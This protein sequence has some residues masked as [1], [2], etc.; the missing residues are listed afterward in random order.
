M[1]TN[2]LVRVVTFLL[3]S[4]AGCVCMATDKQ[5]KNLEA[6]LQKSFNQL[7]MAVSGLDYP[8]TV[9]MLND[10]VK[11][12]D[13]DCL[14]VYNH[15]LA[16]KK[17]IQSVSSIKSL[18]ITLDGIEKYCRSQDENLAN[19]TCNGAVLSLYFYTTVAQD[20]KILNRIKIYPKQ[21]KNIIF[22]NS[23]YWFYNRPN[24]DAWVSAISVMDIDWRNDIHK[25]RTLSLFRKD[26]EELKNETFVAK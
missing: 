26:I 19:F 9:D 12:N 23:F 13:K 14:R 18:D 20:T 21:I 4:L 3:F 10:C 16:G 1:Q 22:R 2:F 25:Q 6:V 17:M 8:Y 5:Q 24:K 15:T 7:A 11:H